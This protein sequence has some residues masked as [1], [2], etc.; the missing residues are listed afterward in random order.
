MSF[1]SDYW[2]AYFGE[3]QGGFAYI[4]FQI[5]SCVSMVLLF[6]W[7]L[8]LEKPKK[9]KMNP[10]LFSILKGT[11]LFSALLLCNYFFSALSLLVIVS[12]RLSFYFLNYFAL[13]PSFL[14]CFFI[15]KKDWAER[16]ARVFTLY[17]TMTLAPTL[18]RFVSMLLS[19]EVHGFLFEFFDTFFS[20]LLL[21]II[22]AFLY[23]LNCER[24]QN[25]NRLS[26]FL[27][28]TIQVLVLITSLLNDPSYSTT[29]KLKVKHVVI[30]SGL[31]C[32]A[33]FIYLFHFVK[34]QGQEKALETQKLAFIKKNQNEMIELSME[35]DHQIKKMEESMNK[36]YRHMAE[37]LKN[38]DYEQLK[39]YFADLSENSFVPLTFVDCGNNAIS[40]I[41]NIEKAKARKF[42]VK[43]HHTI[44]VPKGDIGID[45]YDLC[46]FFTNI[47]D[48]AI[49]GTNRNVISKGKDIY[50]NITYEKPYLIS[51]ITNPTDLKKEDLEKSI[52][53][54][55]K[56]DDSVHGYG[57]KIVE[58]I[59]KKYGDGVVDYSIENG[60]FKV[61]SMLLGGIKDGK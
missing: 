10:I 25:K 57:R 17:N 29:E 34:H 40:C 48:N 15:G 55:S 22:T 37:L 8:I 45:E 13:I 36:Q 54:T 27:V 5:L 59:A 9:N 23:V 2:N 11:G 32:V 53:H 51:V 30:F 16:L 56:S 1:L 38:E 41:I 7:D 44:L 47:I 28:L 50:V 19:G 12:C 43:I 31:Y 14:L 49:E 46:S 18:S 26:V 35:N 6:F 24:F 4:P 42:N 58:S 39:K 33:L 3:R 21:F 61:S 20:I 60:I 52:A